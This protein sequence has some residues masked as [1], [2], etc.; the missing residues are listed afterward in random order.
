MMNDDSLKNI[1]AVLSYLQEENRSI[2][3]TKLYDDIRSGLLR[4][5]KDK[6]FKLKEVKRYA[7]SLPFSGTPERLAEEAGARLAE[8]EEQEIRR[9]K[10]VADK[11]EFNLMVRK[12]EYIRR[13]AVFQELAI[14][15]VALASGLK[16]F[17]ESRALDLVAEVEGNPKKTLN[18][19][20]AL[21]GGLDAALNEYAQ[22]D[23]IE[24]IFAAPPTL[25]G[26]SPITDDEPYP[27]EEG[28]Q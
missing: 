12:G 18:L 7:A 3:K 22:T 1:A 2:A 4:R 24:L 21:E 11:E 23:N 25:E 14:R 15:A 20:R 19:V 16:T 27:A 13:D 26:E 28:A 8:R 10:A 17:F 9:I 5:Q 6:S